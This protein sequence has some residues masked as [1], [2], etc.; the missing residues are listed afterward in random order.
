MLPL[1]HLKN[2]SDDGQ[3]SVEF[4]LLL[5]VV[6]LVFSLFIQAGII[7]RDS[8]LVSNATREAAR[9]LTVTDDRSMALSKARESIDGINLE[10]ER[11]PE[12]G[13]T[14][15]VKGI[16]RVEIHILFLPSFFSLNLEEKISMRV[17]K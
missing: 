3:S 17:E 1:K 9:L 13:S 14:L 5:P 7:V 10:I 11:S 15:K 12:V 6:V 4:A 16:K 2:K 8:I